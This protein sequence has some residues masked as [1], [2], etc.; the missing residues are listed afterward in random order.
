MFLNSVASAEEITE[1]LGSQVR[2][3]V[4]LLVQAFSES[5][6]EAKAQGEPSPLPDD[7]DEIYAAVVSTMMR[8]VFLLFAEDDTVVPVENGMNG[9]PKTAT[10]R[11]VSLYGLSAVTLTFVDSAEIGQARQE[12]FNRMGDLGLPDGI[13]PSVSPP[14]SPSGLIYRYVL[15]SSDRSPMD[16]KTIEEWTVEPKFRAV[17]GVADDSGFGQALT[18]P[19]QGMADRFGPAAQWLRQALQAHRL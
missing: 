14:S 6:T 18:D 11:S 8:M 2:R 15:E 5:A 9:I 1:A 10:M 17:P 3:A 7:G 19:R 4:E 12:V 13:T 16:L